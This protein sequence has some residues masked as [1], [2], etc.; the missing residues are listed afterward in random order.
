MQGR[1]DLI[2]PPGPALEM[3]QALRQAGV[4]AAVLLLPYAD[5]AFDLF[6]TRWSPMARQ[7]LW[8]AERFLE[9]VASKPQSP[10]ARLQRGVH[11]YAM[12]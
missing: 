8:H 11:A 5:H 3:Q 6:G 1:D 4:Q 9:W 12:D 7:A 2:V 10:S